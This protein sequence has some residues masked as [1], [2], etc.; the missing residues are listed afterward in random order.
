MLITVSSVGRHWP[1][2]YVP[3]EEQSTRMADKVTSF[4]REWFAWLILDDDEHRLKDGFRI[5]GSHQVLIRIMAPQ[6]KHA[7]RLI[8]FHLYDHQGSG[9]LLAQMDTNNSTFPLGHHFRRTRRPSQNLQTEGDF[10]LANPSLS[11]HP[12][13]REGDHRLTGDPGG[14]KESDTTEPLTLR[15]THTHT[16]THSL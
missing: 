13:G 6:P 7:A 14:G 5:T 3:F 2:T 11:A 1:G 10:I 4:S 9:C 16:H 15:H 8:S 12:R